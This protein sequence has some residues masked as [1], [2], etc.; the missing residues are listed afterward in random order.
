MKDRHSIREA[1]VYFYKGRGNLYSLTP[2]RSPRLLAA[3]H[4]ISKTFSKA[5]RIR[6][7]YFLL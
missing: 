4:I 6:P 2:K 5:S 1:C 3:R 7:V